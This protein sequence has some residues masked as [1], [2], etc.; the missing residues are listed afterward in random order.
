MIGIGF[1]SLVSGNPFDFLAMAEIMQY[2]ALFN[3]VEFN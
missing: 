3:F 2:L 1:M